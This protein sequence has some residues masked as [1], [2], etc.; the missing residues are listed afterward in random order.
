MKC[1]L[2]IFTMKKI[3]LKLD[4]QLHRTL[5]AKA[6]L[7]GKSMQDYAIDILKKYVEK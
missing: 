3:Q 1:Q 5:K 4:D 2:V 6:A 7:D